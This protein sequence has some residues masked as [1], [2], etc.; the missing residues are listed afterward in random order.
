MISLIAAACVFL[1]I[2]ILISGTRLRD[3]ITDAIG[4]KPYTG[5]FALASLGAIVWLCIAYNHASASSDNRVLFYA[6]Q[7]VHNLAIPIIALAFAIGAPGVLMGNPTSAGQEKAQVSGVLRIT[8]HPF[9]WGVMIWSGYHL[10]AT[11]SLASVIFFGTFFVVASLGTRAIDGK[12]RRKRNAQWQGISAQT[13]NL[14]FAAIIAGR[15]R[16][17]AREYFDWRL[18]VAAVLF[19]VLLYFHT[20]L[21]SISPYP[22]G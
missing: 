4:E 22:N 10:V 1:G 17:V 13:S 21:F 19:L 9:L 5:L 3:V 20:Y 16:F 12:V 14:P 18:G 7:T 8:R 2:H 11:G 15:N 6:G